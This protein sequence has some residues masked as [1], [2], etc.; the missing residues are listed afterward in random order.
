[1][2]VTVGALAYFTCYA[3]EVM[4]SRRVASVAFVA[5]V[6]GCSYDW[7]IGT[8]SAETP[9]SS[10]GAP[11][12]S[13][14][15]TNPTTDGGGARDTGTRDTGTLPNGTRECGATCECRNNET[16]LFTCTKGSCDARCTDQSTC[17]L[18]CAPNTDC[19]IACEESSRCNLD[20]SMAQGSTC[21]MTCEDRAD[22]KGT[23][24]LGTFCTRDCPRDCALTCVPGAICT[25]N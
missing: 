11:S 14:T 22:C 12:G 6:V 18:T 21:N 20:C 10:S 3:S 25:G 7:N 16:C 4:V 8:G 24:G 23:C 2:T 5:L 19:A 15:P 17:T 13:A 9:P 1:V